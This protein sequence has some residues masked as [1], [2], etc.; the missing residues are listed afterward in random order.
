MPRSTHFQD[1][2]FTPPPPMITGLKLRLDVNLDGPSGTAE[3]WIT[4]SELA[5]GD[6]LACW[7]ERTVRLDAMPDA[8]TEVLADALRTALRDLAPF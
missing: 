3:T 2:L 4:L 8:A 5:T 6:Q 7:S 1:R